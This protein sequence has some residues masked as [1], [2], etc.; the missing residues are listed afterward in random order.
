MIVGFVALGFSRGPLAGC[1]PRDSST[2]TKIEHLDLYRTVSS[3]KSTL[4]TTESSVLR[5][6][7]ETKLSNW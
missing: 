2:K 4:Y 1:L 3:L 6:N 7:S 5:G